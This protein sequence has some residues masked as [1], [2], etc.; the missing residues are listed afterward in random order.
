MKYADLSCTGCGKKFDSPRW[1]SMAPYGSLLFTARGNFGSTVYDPMEDECLLVIICDDCI[2]IEQEKRNVMRVVPVRKI[3][4][5]V[6]EPWEGPGG[7]HP[8]G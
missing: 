1:E 6:R 8:E 7:D 2:L 5:D 4:E 3:A